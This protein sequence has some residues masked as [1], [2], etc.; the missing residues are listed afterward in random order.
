MN[1]KKEI[2]AIAVKHFDGNFSPVRQSG[3]REEGR[4]G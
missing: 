3:E 4:G 1:T 2:S